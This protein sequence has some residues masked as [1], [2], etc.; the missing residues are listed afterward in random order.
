VPRIGSYAWALAVLAAEGQRGVTSEEL[1]GLVGVNATQVRRDLSRLL[2]R[3][4]KRGVG[5][6]VDRLIEALRPDPTT[7]LVL[8]DG[9]VARSLG[10]L[11]QVGGRL[12]YESEVLEAVGFLL[13]IGDD[14]PEVALLDYTHPDA[15]RAQATDFARAGVPLIVN[16]ADYRITD[17][18]FSVVNASPVLALLEAVGR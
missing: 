12:R 18:R 6:R 2:G 1:G 5:Y 7:I 15:G 13:P 14:L 3:A 11:C 9:P 4:G 8:G 17:E 16:Y 10:A